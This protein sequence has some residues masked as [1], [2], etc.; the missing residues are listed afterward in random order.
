M[1]RAHGGKHRHADKHA[2][3][4]PI[5]ASQEPR[6]LV[7][8]PIIVP[9]ASEELPG[10]ADTGVFLHEILECVSLAELA[11]SPAF[12]AWSALPT[13]TSLVEKLCRRHSR[14]AEHGASAIRLVHTAYT[15]PARLGEIVMP[16]LAFAHTA[17]REMEFLFPI[18]EKVHPLLSRPLGP[19]GSRVW[20]IARGVVNGVIDFLFEYGDKVYLCDWKSDR[21]PD[22][23]V[24]TLARHCDQNYDVQARIYTL[25]TLRLLGITTS[26]TYAN[27]FGGLLFC[28]LRGR[29][30]EDADAGIYFSRPNWEE[31]VA[32]ET[33]M[34]EDS[35]GGLT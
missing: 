6:S 4:V 30:P 11:N 2:P 8:S 33:S 21:L 27:R 28:F 19:D 25:A 34:V 20:T 29:Q 9:G 35:F 15:A 14:P 13:V 10:G 22:W 16:R 1:K 24:R 7:G 3:G 23:G 32:W 31:V 18:P 17:L 12:P 5:E 26:T